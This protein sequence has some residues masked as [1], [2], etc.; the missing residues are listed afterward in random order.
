[1]RLVLNPST[2]HLCARTVV[3]V[4]TARRLPPEGTEEVR[5][6]LLEPSLRFFPTKGVGSISQKPFVEKLPIMQSA[7]DKPYFIHSWPFCEGE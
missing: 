6:L 5:S 3:W 7:S 1:M 2:P 4:V